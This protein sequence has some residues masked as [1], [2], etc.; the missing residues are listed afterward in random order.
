MHYIQWTT[1]NQELEKLQRFTQAYDYFRAKE[2]L[3]KLSEVS[4]LVQ[5]VE[6]S[7]R[8]VAEMAERLRE[9][10]EEIANLTKQKEKVRLHSVHYNY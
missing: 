2:S 10:K 6:A 8:A 5:S 9:I 7:K 3:E 4:E 1:N